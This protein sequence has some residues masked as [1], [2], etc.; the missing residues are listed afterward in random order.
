MSFFRRFFIFSLSLF[1]SLSLSLWASFPAFYSSI[2]VDSSDVRAT[3]A[4]SRKSSEI[5]PCRRAK[6]RPGVR[7]IDSCFALSW[8][9]ITITSP[10]VLPSLSL[11]LFSLCPTL[12]LL[13]LLYS[14]SSPSIFFN[15]VRRAYCVKSFLRR[16]VSFLSFQT[17]KFDATRRVERHARRVLP[18][19]EKIAR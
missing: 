10:F 3:R 16:L 15:R 5:F 11:S 18:C 17:D 4:R 13:L 8:L 1:L 2:V 19:S 14:F 12:P 7:E 9:L 6:V